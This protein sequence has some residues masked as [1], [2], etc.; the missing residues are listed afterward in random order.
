MD[1]ILWKKLKS[2]E[3]S[4]LEQIYS[5]H[6]AVM[7]K[8]GRRFSA[9]GQLV[10]DCVQD[11]FIELWNHREGLG[12][13]DSIRKY[14]LLSLRRKII[15][16]VSTSRYSTNEPEEGAFE[17]VFDIEQEIIGGEI[18][19]ERQ[20]R[21]KDALE[22]LTKRQQEILY[23]KYYT[24]LDYHAIGEIMDLNYQ[25]ARNLAFRALEALRELMLLAVLWAMRFF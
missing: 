20:K 4:A 25:S 10:E 3:K 5:E 21:L 12:M 1:S 2:G 18:D 13:T 9:D 11:L 17:A 6:A 15:R 19:A 8:Y 14:L 22:G 24:D 7:L 23:L 16:M